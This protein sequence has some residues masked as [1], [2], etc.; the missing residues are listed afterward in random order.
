MVIVVPGR[1][2]AAEEEL[3]EVA[4]GPAVDI[5][6]DPERDTAEPWT[7]AVRD[8][9]SSTRAHVISIGSLRL[10]A[11]RSGGLGVQYSGMTAEYREHYRCSRKRKN[12]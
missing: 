5:G 11:L 4:C 6:A 10:D 3:D 1:R 9:E 2:A 7:K 12:C 8:I